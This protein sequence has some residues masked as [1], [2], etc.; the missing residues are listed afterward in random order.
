MD[1]TGKVALVGNI[2]RDDPYSQENIELGS[3]FNDCIRQ[4]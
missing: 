2:F 4:R 3:F 1:S